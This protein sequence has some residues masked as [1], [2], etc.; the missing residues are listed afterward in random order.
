MDFGSSNSGND[1]IYH[2]HSNFDSYHWISTFADPGFKLHT[3][4]GQ[5]LAILLFHLVDSALIP[6]DM[7]NAAKVLKDYYADLQATIATA[8]VSLD[9]SA[10]EA[11]L[12]EFED[13]AEKIE[14]AGDC[15]VA[16]GDENTVNAINAKL[17]YFQRGFASQGGLPRRSTFKNVITAP[18]LDNGEFSHF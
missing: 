10:M 12:E 6:F 4:V 13:R 11:A 8:N 17:R 9:T 14:A 7:P 18:G 15:A 3:S 16:L 5:Y 2:Y 1:P